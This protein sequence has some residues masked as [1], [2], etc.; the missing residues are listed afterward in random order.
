MKLLSVAASKPDENKRVAD[1]LRDA[2]FVS[3][4]YLRRLKRRPG[5]LLLNGEPVYTTHR[6]RAGDVVAFD[7]SDGD[8]L[9]IRSA[10]SRK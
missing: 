4:T 3:E 1:V 2:F 10:S 9:P 8:R 5:A 6:L 7:P